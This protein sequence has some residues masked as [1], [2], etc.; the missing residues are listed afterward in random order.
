M[1]TGVEAAVPVL[2]VR[3]AAAAQAFYALFGYR[4][5]QAGGDGD[6][7]WSYLKAGQHTILLACVQPAL[8]PSELPLLIYLYVSDLAAVREQF[9]AAGLE[10][11]LT[12]YPDHAPGGE[13]RTRD[14][15]GNVVLVGQ[16]AVVTDQARS[17]PSGPEARFSLIK[18]AAEAISRRGGAP[19]TC[20]IPAVN[21]SA[22][23]QPAEIKL[24]DT[25]GV[26]VW[27]CLAHADEAL[28]N[29]PGAFIASED[30]QGLGPWLT[31]RVTTGD[32]S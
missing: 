13:L 32:L 31:H 5:M 27:A 18:Q 22:C 28:I 4:Q 11:Q 25:W 19:A 14:P 7:Q 9:D 6:A 10:Y 20:Q 3:N 17:A 21:G 29:A 30:A 24:A 23:A 1:Q 2:Y 15:D 16:R 26:T 12:G 8:I